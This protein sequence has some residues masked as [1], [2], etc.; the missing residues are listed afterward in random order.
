MVLEKTQLKFIKS[1]ENGELIGFVS[2]NPVTK[3]LMGVNENSKF[4]KRI[5]LLS[6]ELKGSVIPKILYDV[7]LK[8]MNQ[9]NGYIVVA[10][11]PKLFAAKITSTI[12]PRSVY[13]IKV[14]FGL[15]KIYFDPLRG[16]TPSSRTL[17]GV[18]E[19]LNGRHDLAEIDRVISDFI[20][21]ANKLLTKMQEDGYQTRDLR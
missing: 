18:L 10:A 15:K 21:Q 14:A 8:L 9:G 20:D 7:E 13:R 3:K 19:E 2:R 17:K 1:E 6:E 16:K 11:V 5:C 12:I 4:K